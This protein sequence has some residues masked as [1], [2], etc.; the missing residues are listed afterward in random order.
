MKNKN[1]K[2]IEDKIEDKEKVKDDNFYLTLATDK[3]YK[4]KGKTFKEA[5]ESLGLS[6]NIIKLKCN[7]I[8]RKGD[9][10]VN[11]LYTIKEIRQLINSKL[12]RDIWERKFELRLK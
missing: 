3:E 6:W 12:L 9:K 5:F 11:Q 10:K 8:V 7:L 4:G 2:K 1:T